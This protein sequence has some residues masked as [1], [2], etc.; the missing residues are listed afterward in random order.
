MRSY[1]YYMPIFPECQTKAGSYRNVCLGSHPRQ[2]DATPLRKSRLSLVEFKIIH[3]HDQN[4]RHSTQVTLTGPHQKG[5]AGAPLCLLP[6]LR[7]DE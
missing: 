6:K 4:F 3:G 5:L 7:S 1:K 2:V